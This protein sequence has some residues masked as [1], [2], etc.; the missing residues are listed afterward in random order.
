MRRSVRPDAP[1]HEPGHDCFGGARRFSR[2]VA[3]ATSPAYTCPDTGPTWSLACNGY[4]F[5]SPCEGAT[6]SNGPTCQALRRSFK[7]GRPRS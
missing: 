7:A 3:P 4:P 5:A 1:S 6:Q 2:L